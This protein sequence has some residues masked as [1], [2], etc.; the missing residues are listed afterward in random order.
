MVR[1]RGS[2]TFFMLNSAEHEIFNA[3]K[4]KKNIKKLSI[5][6]ALLSLECYFFCSHMNR[7]NFILSSVEPER[8]FITS[9]TDYVRVTDEA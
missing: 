5:F 7:K 9:G 2:K 6:L 8:S 3:H 1:A 4:N